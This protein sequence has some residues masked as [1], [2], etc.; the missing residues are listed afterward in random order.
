MSRNRLWRAT[1]RACA[2]AALSLCV[3]AS[4]VGLSPWAGLPHAKAQPFASIPL[5]VHEAIRPIVLANGFDGG[6][7]RVQPGDI[8]GAAD[9]AGLA[10]RTL[11]YRWAK[12]LDA[13]IARFESVLATDNDAASAA[14]DEAVARVRSAADPII[15]AQRLVHHSIRYRFDAPGRDHWQTPL[16]TL[17][18]GAGDC[19]DHAV[20]KRALLLQAGLDPDGISLLFV[21]TAQ[22]IGHVLVQVETDA[23]VRILDSR[24]RAQR[25]GRLLPGDQVLAELRGNHRHVISGL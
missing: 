17:R 4:P 6:R 5:I 8:P 1:G 21:R 7:E 22:G 24:T 3:V 10:P 13:Q 19:E 15:E 16:Q 25:I 9:L 20:L 23:G 2:G 14:W 11:R 12:H 18:R